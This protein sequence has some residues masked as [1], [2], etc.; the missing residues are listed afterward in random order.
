MNVIVTGATGFIGKALTRLL[1]EKGHQVIVLSRS[2]AKAEETFADIPVTAVR[3]DS[4]TAH[5][6]AEYADGADAIVNLAGETIIGLWTQNKK[7]AIL[8]S[9]LD[10]VNA[11]AEALRQAKTKP[12]VVIHGSA[13]CYPPDTPQPCDESSSFGS[14]YLNEVTKLFE[15]AAA[16][17]ASPDVRQVVI[18]TGMVLGRGGG[19]LEPMVKSFNFFLGGWFGS[20]S[21]WLSW[22]S[23][24]D[25]IS[26]IQFLMEHDDCGGIFNLTAPQPLIM[27]DF[28][29][30]LGKALHRPCLFSIPA[31]AARIAT[32]QL[33]DEVLL[34][35]QNAIPKRLLE[36]GYV[37]RHTDIEQA[38]SEIFGRT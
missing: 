11:V 3:W 22:I 38:L 32:G 10:A 20:G 9:R 16:K 31:F 24:D 23:L 13:I 19:M 8:Q 4:R 6:W 1:V 33:A 30:M 27:K 26:A 2:L 28:C 18:R 34:S 36:A 7:E 5:G 21:Q 14:G 12:K 37:F 17:A 25:E 35:G 29:R 15:D